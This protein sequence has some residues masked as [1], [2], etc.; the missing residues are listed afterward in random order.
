MCHSPLNLFIFCVFVFSAQMK[1]STN[2]TR[3][4]LK[5]PK[6]VIYMNHVEISVQSTLP[7]IVAFCCC[8]ERRSVE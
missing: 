7:V 5:E 3:L 1:H 2:I 8:S 4:R 6:H